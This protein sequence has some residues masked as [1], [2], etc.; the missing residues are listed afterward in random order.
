M[1][2]PRLPQISRSRAHVTCTQHSTFR[3]AA[4]MVLP[5]CTHRHVLPIVQRL[6]SAST[7]DTAR[8]AM[9]AMRGTASPAACPAV[10]PAA[11]TVAEATT[12]GASAA[13]VPSDAG[14]AVA[15]EAAASP[16]SEA[17]IGAGGELQKVWQLPCSD[18]SGFQLT[19]VLRVC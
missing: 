13:A 18:H 17:A 3:T 14:T 1:S 5:I 2:F 19:R 6:R 4:C 8:A 12:A 11:D 10:Q 9:A 7:S 15:A 16:A